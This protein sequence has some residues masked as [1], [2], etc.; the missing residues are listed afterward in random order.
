MYKS[1]II[2]FLSLTSC[3]YHRFEYD[4]NDG[5][6]PVTKVLLEDMKDTFFFEKAKQEYGGARLID[7][8]RIVSSDTSFIVGASLMLCESASWESQINEY[9]QGIDI[10]LEGDTKY[11][12]EKNLDCTG[13][14]LRLE[15]T[16]II[17][18]EGGYTLYTVI[19]FNSSDYCV[20]SYVYT[21]WRGE[22]ETCFLL[23]IHK[24]K[25]PGIIFYQRSPE[26]K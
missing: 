16:Y 22:Y 20:Q 2:I 21:F 3:S 5:K 13:G 18:K 26:T 11:I 10:H 14:N 15:T 4:L 17:E 24:T 8:F 9:L 1:I 6:K 25:I 12:L 7:G 23:N 19:S